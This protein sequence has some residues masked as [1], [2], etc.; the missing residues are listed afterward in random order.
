[1]L[2]I[3]GKFFVVDKQHFGFPVVL[4]VVTFVNVL[5]NPLLNLKASDTIKLLSSLLSLK[6]I[7]LISHSHKPKAISP[8]LLLSQGISDYYLPFSQGN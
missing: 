7:V 1:M 6:L 8:L 5:I 3:K 2:Q 4:R